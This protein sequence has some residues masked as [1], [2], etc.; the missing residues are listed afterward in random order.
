MKQTTESIIEHAKTLVILVILAFFLRSTIV[1]AYKIPSSSMVPTLHIGDFILVNKLSYGLR[2]PF[3]D[4]LVYQY[5]TPRRGDVIVFTRPDLP[6]TEEDES[7][8][9]LIKRVVGLPG[10]TVEVRGTKVYIN[11]ELL[12]GDDEHAHWVS[13]GIK[14]FGPMKIPENHLFMMG[15]NRDASKDSRFWVEDHYSLDVKRVKGRAFVI[16]WNKEFELGR[17]FKIIH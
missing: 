15:D 8:T 16:Y 4:E 6:S 10:E 13:G 11:G 14:D 17:I 5:D 7:E 3:V 12:N 1:E 9:N 2:L